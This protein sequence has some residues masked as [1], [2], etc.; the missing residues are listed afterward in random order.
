MRISLDLDGT[1]WK[2]RLFFAA[3]ARALQ[4][5]GHKVGVLTAHSEEIRDADLRLWWARGF[6]KP[7][8]FYNAADI[9]RSGVQGDLRTKK[10]A[11]A[12]N[13][14]IDCHIDDWDNRHP[15]EIEMALIGWPDESK[16]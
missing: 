11:F 15:D 2:Y 12:L 14:G 4:A 3:L 1:A 10:L 13:V 8:F 5:S 9:E 7:D 6:P 16:S